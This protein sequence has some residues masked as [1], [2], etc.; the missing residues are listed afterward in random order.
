MSNPSSAR[1]IDVLVGLHGSV[2][3]TKYPYSA[4][5]LRF[6]VISEGEL[7]EALKDNP[8]A[9][10]VDIWAG[11]TATQKKERIAGQLT[12][13]IDED[14]Y[15]KHWSEA[16]MAEGSWKEFLQSYCNLKAVREPIVGDRYLRPD[17]VENLQTLMRIFDREVFTHKDMAGPTL[18][19][20]SLK[21]KWWKE[22]HRVFS[23][24][25]KVV[26]YNR[27][28]LDSLP[29]DGICYSPTWDKATAVELK[30]MASRW[31]TSPL[32]QQVQGSD[33][34]TSVDFTSNNERQVKEFLQK[35][36]FTEKYLQ[37][38]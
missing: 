10:E 33:I 7:E 17:E 18:L 31:R 24:A 32:W 15:R 19:K 9:S 34:D 25:A 21:S 11:L 1:L 2:G 27:M 30:G 38:G 3:Q 8:K 23:N 37:T 22:C 35:H 29:D 4:R 5:V 12:L 16:G 26:I 20:A 28:G 13:R 36:G 6:G 14:D